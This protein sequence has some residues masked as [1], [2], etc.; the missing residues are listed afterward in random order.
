MQK[1]NYISA[2]V[3]YRK[4]QMIDPDANKACNM[5]LALMKQGRH[6][7]SRS[8]LEEVVK[9]SLPGSDDT[10]SKNRAQ[11]LLLELESYEQPHI[12][13]NLVG[14]NFDVDGLGPHD[15]KWAPSRPRRL[16]VFEEISS[17]KDQLAC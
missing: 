12:L 9:G 10:K 7:E 5:A 15:R 1:K 14:L 16:P 3:V 6:E 13:S 11:E 4:A 8:M 17:F 2:E